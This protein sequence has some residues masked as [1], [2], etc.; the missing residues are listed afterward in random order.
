[1]VEHLLGLPLKHK[2]KDLGDVLITNPS[3]NEILTYELASA[4]WKNKANVLL[5]DGSRAMTGDLNFAGHQAINLVLEKL[6]TSPTFA[7]GRIWL[8][9]AG[10]PLIFFSPDGTTERTL[11]TDR[12]THYKNYQDWN[13]E[14]LTETSTVSLT[15]VTLLETIAKPFPLGH[16]VEFFFSHNVKNMGTLASRGATFK[17]VGYDSLGE[18]E[19]SDPPL[20]FRWTD[21]LADYKLM[22]FMSVK[23]LN[24]AVGN[25]GFRVKWKVDDANYACWSKTRYF[26]ARSY[27]WGGYVAFET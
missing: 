22:S 17:L 4:L 2:L 11:E 19:L 24:S 6:A 16:Q 21:G 3:D 9:T 14:A 10:T 5:L 18:F 23:L 15:Y 27:N 26:I 1:M 13:V 20:E 12:H 8:K 25:L 7:Q